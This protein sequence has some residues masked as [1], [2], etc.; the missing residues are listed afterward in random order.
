MT[1][2]HDFRVAVPTLEPDDQLI[3]LVVELSAG[4]PTRADPWQRCVVPRRRARANWSRCLHR[5]VT[6]RRRC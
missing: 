2:L 5:E 3:A 1:F 6:P 4:S